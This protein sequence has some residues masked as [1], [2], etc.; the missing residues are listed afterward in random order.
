MGL[1]S[2]VSSRTYSLCRSHAANYSLRNRR[3]NLGLYEPA[4]E[5][6]HPQYLGH[7]SPAPSIARL[8]HISKVH[9]RFPRKPV[10]EHYIL[11]R[12]KKRRCKQIHSLS[13]RYHSPHYLSIRT[14]STKPQ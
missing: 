9:R 13:K 1:I 8:H 14:C 7:T 5:E 2:R 11:L 12:E 6:A 4:I 3:H 10:R